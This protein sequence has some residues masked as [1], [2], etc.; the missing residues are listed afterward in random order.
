MNERKD[1][2]PE[3]IAPKLAFYEDETQIDAN[4]L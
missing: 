4:M 2:C 3:F 1:K